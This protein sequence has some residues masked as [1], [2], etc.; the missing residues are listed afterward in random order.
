MEENILPLLT[1]TINHKKLKNDT[2]GA[3]VYVDIMTFKLSA[4][5][6][7]WFCV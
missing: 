7:F 6:A 3:H 1:G 2:I 4:L 5:L